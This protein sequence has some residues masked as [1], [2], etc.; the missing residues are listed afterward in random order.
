MWGLL[1]FLGSCIGLAAWGLYARNLFRGG[2]EHGLDGVFCGTWICSTLLWDLALWSVFMA[3]G[4][5]GLVIGWVLLSATY[6]ALFRSRQYTPFDVW[7]DKME[8]Y[9]GA[10]YSPFRRWL[11]KWSQR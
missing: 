4:M 3:L 7:L 10:K 11:D 6:S 5:F 9:R 1:K 2:L 8:E